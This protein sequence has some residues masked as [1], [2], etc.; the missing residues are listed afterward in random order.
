MVIPSEAITH[1]AAAFAGSAFTF[2]AVQGRITAVRNQFRSTYE[3]RLEKTRREM[4]QRRHLA[5]QHAHERGKKE[6]RDE[7]VPASPAPAGPKHPNAGKSKRMSKKQQKRQARQA[8]APSSHDRHRVGS[9]ASTDHGLTGVGA[10][11]GGGCSGGSVSSG[12][13]DSGGM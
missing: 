9:P 13:C 6:G 8:S 7:A 11:F 2:I 12:G 5:E 1:L 3:E 10:S 4:A